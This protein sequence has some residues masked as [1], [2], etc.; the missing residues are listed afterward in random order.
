LLPLETLEMRIL[1]SYTNDILN[2]ASINLE[3]LGEYSKKEDMQNLFHGRSL[4]KKRKL[5]D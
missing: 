5:N 4:G 1:A 3:K 2:I